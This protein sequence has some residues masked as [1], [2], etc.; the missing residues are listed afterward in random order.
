MATSIAPSASSRRNNSS[1]ELA[2]QVGKYL[3]ALELGKKHYKRADALMD[4]IEKELQPGQVITL[5]TGKV[6]RFA[7][8]FE[9][10][11]RINVGMNARR[12]EFEE[13]VQV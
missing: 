2:Q 3:R 10:R 4:S 9:S 11:T 8:K 13:V 12:Y 7:D 1:R 5:L 6:V